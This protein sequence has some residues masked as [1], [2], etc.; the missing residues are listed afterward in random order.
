M[1]SVFARTLAARLR[2]LGSAEDGIALPVAMAATVI[3]LAFAAV[4]VTASVN[5]QTGGTRDHAS[6]QA[7]AAADAGLNLALMRQNTLGPTASLPCVV[8]NGDQL[9]L[10]KTKN[11]GWCP[12]V[13]PT[14]VGD[15]TFTY[16]VKPEYDS[17]HATMSVVV[18]GSTSLASGQSLTRRIKATATGSGDS[19]GGGPVVFGTEGIIG[20]DKVTMTNGAVYG[21]VGSNGNIEWP[22]GDA[23]IYGCSSIRVGSPSG[24]FKKQSWQKY[25][26]CPIVQEDREYPNVVVPTANSNGRMFTAGGD[27]YTYSSGALGGCGAASGRASWCP[28]TRV[29]YLTSDARVTLGGT[30]PYVFC[31]LRMD[32]DAKLFLAAGVRVQIVFDSP[33]NCGQS[34]GVEQ[35]SLRNGAALKSLGPP[36]TAGSVVPGL[37]FVGSDSRA[38]KIYM[39]GGTSGNN[40][41][42]YAP[43]SSIEIRAGASFGGAI[44]GKTIFMDGGTR[45]VPQAG[46]TFDPDEDLPVE[47][48]SDEPS[49]VSRESYVECDAEVPSLEQD[50]DTGCH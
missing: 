33:E 45:L 31:Q 36:G 29:L 42:I 32:N 20:I 41:I 10:G 46:T 4:V 1:T 25:P 38:T 44:L 11:A 15:A 18:T 40:M 49:S 12:K 21:N 16:W 37:Y 50:P 3:G 13:G 43:R 34:S 9:E 27:T 35:F 7:L 26:S 8:E 30:A 19:G 23:H 24:E 5:T 48:V 28:T 17:S 2:A 47:G 6:E 39:D 14:T 22:T